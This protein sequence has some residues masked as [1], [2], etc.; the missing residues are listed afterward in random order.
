MEEGVEQITGFE[1]FYVEPPMRP[2][3]AEEEL[4]LYDPKLGVATYL[5]PWVNIVVRKKSFKSIVLLDVSTSIAN[6]FFR[7]ISRL[8][9]FALYFPHFT[10][11]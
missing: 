8:A 11:P 10:G 6:V 2:D 5:L 3:E 9:G 7:H 1:E 4:A